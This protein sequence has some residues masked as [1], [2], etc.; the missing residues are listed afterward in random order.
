MVVLAG[1]VLV[2]CGNGD[3]ANQTSTA[4][5]LSV[6][7]AWART[8][9]MSVSVGAV[10]MTISSDTS[11][12]LVSA[13]V[14]ASI[15]ARAE[16]H[17]TVSVGLPGEPGADA[18]MSGDSTSD[19][20]MSSDSTGG[21]SDQMTMQPI[22]SLAIPAGGTVELSPG[23]YHIMLFDLAAP[24]EVGKKFDITLTFATAGTVVVSVE[25]RDDAP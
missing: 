12:E 14:D 6:S 11:D 23:G 21:M 22:E 25:V 15:A 13:S 8:S 4:Q 24:L 5:G 19:A 1:S 2:G 17:E 3:E 7:A 10:Y 18:S 20:T 9:P 16:I